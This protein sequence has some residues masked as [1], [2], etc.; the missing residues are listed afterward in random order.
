MTTPAT[1]PQ[2]LIPLNSPHALLET[3][4]GKGLNLIKLAQAGFSVPNGFLIPTT[5]YHEFV[6]QNQLEM[7]IS[8]ILQDLDFTSLEA[9]SAASDEIRS[10]FKQGS[11]SSQLGTILEVGWRWLGAHPVAVRSSATAEDLPELSF[12][13]QQD[14]FLNVIGTEALTTA[15]VDCWSSLW[16]A[17][18]IG[19]RA[20]NQIPHDEVA[21]SVVVQ[22]MVP[23]ETSGVLFTA[24]P[25]NGR[26]SETVIDATLGLGEALVSGLV[27][28]DHYTIDTQNNEITHKFLGSKAVVISGKSEGG[29]TTQ[30]SDASQIQAIPDEIVLQLA[31]IGKQIEKLYNFPQDIEWA[32]G[33]SLSGGEGDSIFILQSRPITSLYPLPE[34]LP[35]EPLKT[36]IGLHVIQGVLEPF[37]PLGQTA[38]TEVLIGGGRALGLNFTIEQ[39]TAFYV[40][41]E[42]LWINMTPIVR[43]PR[44][45][46]AYPI[47]IKNLDPG[48][49]QAFEEI[50]QDPRLTPQSGS[51]NLLKPW[52]M[53]RFILPNLLRVLRFLRH[54]E[55]MAQKTLL[56]FDDRVA[57]TAAQQKTSGDLATDLSNRVNLLL[58]A[59]TLF[60]D[61]VIPIG[62]TAVVA[63]MVPFYGILRRFSKEAAEFTGDSQFETLY[64]KIA[65][66]LPNNVT[67]EMDLKLWETAQSLQSDT[68]SARVFEVSTAADLASQYQSGTL[69]PVAQ[70]AVATFMERYGMRGLG[71]I[72]IGRPRWRENPEHIMG[73]LQSYLQIDDPALAP[74]MVFARGA[75][76]AQVAA[77]KLEAAVR[78]LPKGHL[79]A[80]LVRF[81]VRRYR[82][83]AGLREAP[84][85]F[86]IRMMGLMRAGLLASGD[87][88]VAAGLLEQDDDLF[89]LHVSELETLAA[90]FEGWKVS[91][92]SP[93][94]LTIFQANIRERRALRKRELHRKQIP[95]VLL[96][97]GTVYYEG[98]RATETKNGQIIGD[99]VSPGVVEGTV[100]VVFNPQGTQ[101]QPGEILVCPGTDPAWTPLFLA[102]GGLVMETGGMMTHGSVVA[103]EY[104]IPAVV[105]VHQAT[106]RLQTGNRVRVDGSLGVVEIIREA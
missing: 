8:D 100:R 57:E 55:A 83:L 39:Q 95:R 76:A 16:T 106:E 12:A 2:P 36:M 72:D 49:A 86:A 45:H 91:S 92:P 24:N 63:G 80:R 60:P 50:L 13:G 102:A 38:I 75:E 77:Q 32:Y 1:L 67:T 48:V 26:R 73:V 66:G 20:R 22:N 4:G 23:S 68:A 78:Q 70:S 47:V 28:P 90:E 89:F 54:P 18:A 53:A 69:P 81:A 71:E 84:K 19:Y 34:N 31:D 30:E 9:L 6:V 87:E 62:V 59:R 56:A 43:H 103:R 7:V 61:F 25:L 41:G 27:E 21:L 51:M 42:R 74:D 29:V 98:L 17:R 10:R 58:G 44:G 11:V 33:P 97:D 37:T 14:T 94:V 3:V 101:L 93:S 99:P 64:L 35:P 82:A 88:M 105:G 15:V 104:G 96:S 46:K 40:A 79:K 5:A 65:R 85:F 52:N